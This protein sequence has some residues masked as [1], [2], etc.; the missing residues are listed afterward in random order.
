MRK[1]T[2]GLQVV[3]VLSNQGASGSSYT[4]S[5]DGTGYSAGT[6]L[7]EI[8]SCATVTVGSDGKVPVP[9]ESG[10]PRVLYP[11]AKLN[12]TSICTG[13]S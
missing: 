7:I 11:S 3:T 8:Y 2:D 6:Q 5:L 9:M 4:L 12:S 13:S 1:G 10:L